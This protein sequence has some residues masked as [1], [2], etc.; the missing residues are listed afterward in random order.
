MTYKRS[1]ISVPD[2]PLFSERL[3]FIK[4][5]RA[6]TNAMWDM[7]SSA[8]V[9]R[10]I[11]LEVE[12]DFEKWRGQFYQELDAGERFKFFYGFKWRDPNANEKDIL[13]LVICRP[14][15][16]EKYIELGYWVRRSFWG[17]GLATEANLKMIELAENTLYAP[18]KD[19]IAFVSIG[20][21][22]SRHVLE[23]SGLVIAGEQ[24]LNDDPCWVMRHASD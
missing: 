18:K 19:H 9:M 4:L 13:G 24:N 7:V 16:D 15:E 2:G 14:T 23:K 8:D 6:D 3:S 5:S 22:A 17:L 10:Y 20:N 1:E 11:P 21:H 12:T